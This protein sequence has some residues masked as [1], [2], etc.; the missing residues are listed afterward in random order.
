MYCLV[1]V[2][3]NRMAAHLISSNYEGCYTKCCISNAADVTDDDSCGM[4]VKETVTLT[5]N[6][7]Q[8]L[9]CCMY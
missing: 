7:R 9:I 2:D 1:S 6:G 4:T 8:N 5:G 3:Y